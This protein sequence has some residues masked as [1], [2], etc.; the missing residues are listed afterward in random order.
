MNDLSGKLG[1]IVGISLVIAVVGWF[2]LSHFL[3]TR[4]DRLPLK[5]KQHLAHLKDELP[6]EIEPGLSLT[7]FDL[8]R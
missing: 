4:D 3:D 6:L 7:D 2:C 1:G 5:V 8:S